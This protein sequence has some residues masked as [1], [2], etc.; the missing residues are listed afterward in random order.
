MNNL[1]SEREER[2]K[3]IAELLRDGLS[4]EEI[5]RRLRT[6]YRA[7]AR[8][9][10]TQRIPVPDHLARR[11]RAELAKAEAKAVAMLRG[12]ATQ[13]TVYAELRVAPNVQ[14]R[15]RKEHG[16]PLRPSAASPPPPAQPSRRTQ[17]GA[18]RETG[19]P[20]SGRTNAAT[21]PNSSSRRLT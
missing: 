7:V 15:L 20:T 10:D 8:V 18:K 2:D 9:R 12:G 16:I 1:P 14:T 21:L 6:S 17:R 5:K 19:P 3:H 13:R 11:S 4:I